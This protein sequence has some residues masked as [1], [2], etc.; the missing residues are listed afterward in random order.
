MRNEM[1]KFS[2]LDVSLCGADCRR[3]VLQL[4][5]ALLLASAART[6]DMEEFISDLDLPGNNYFS[7]K[8]RTLDSK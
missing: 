6:V 8:V 4:V 7:I 3:V 5:V 1:E 2:R